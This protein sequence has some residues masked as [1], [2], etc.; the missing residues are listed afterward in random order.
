[1]KARYYVRIT[2]EHKAKW[3]KDSNKTPQY[4]WST[5]AGAVSRESIRIALTYDARNDLPF[6]E[7]KYKIP[8]YKLHCQNKLHYLW[9][10]IWSG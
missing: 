2:L 5:F 6:L 9:Y 8:I 7:L 3:V 1:M 4:E 10:R